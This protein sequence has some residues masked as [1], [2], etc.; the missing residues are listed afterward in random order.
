MRVTGELVEHEVDSFEQFHSLVNSRF[1]Y[2]VMFRGMKDIDW[3]LLPSI[4]RYLP[5]L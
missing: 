5:L 1:P 4:G 2:G 3:K